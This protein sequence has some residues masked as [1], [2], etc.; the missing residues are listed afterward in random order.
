M[1]Q[2]LLAS[3]NQGKLREI[4]AL[5]QGQDLELLL[6]SQVGI[7]LEVEENGQTYAENAALK[8]IAYAQASH[9]LTLSDDSGLEVDALDGLPGLRSARFAP[10]PNATDADRR[11]YLLERLR[12]KPRPW[13]ARFRCVV[14]LVTPSG[15]VSFAEGICPG[16]I[17]SEE[18]GQNGFGYDPI[19]Y[20]PEKDKTMAELDMEEKN[21]LSHR[22]R[23]VTAA[24]PILLEL[25]RK[26]T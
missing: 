6:P 23:A 11:A 26:M 14:A 1:A 25:L 3:T 5:L 13:M 17:I 20:I 7:D 19:F 21:K 24:I 18:R 16:E 10:Q 22:A 8:G 12:G 15:E 4:Q 9:L 2:I